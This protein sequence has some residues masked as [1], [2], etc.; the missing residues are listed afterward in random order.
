VPQGA[1]ARLIT[2][3][4]AADTFHLF[5]R[6]KNGAVVVG[7]KEMFCITPTA[8][9]IAA[10]GDCA[11][12][13]QQEAGFVRTNTSGQPGFTARIGE[14]GLVPSPPRAPVQAAMPK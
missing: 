6:R 4:L 3:P 8:F 14:K 9:E 7:G 13:K 1:C 5:A 12:S 2:T 10:R 11:R